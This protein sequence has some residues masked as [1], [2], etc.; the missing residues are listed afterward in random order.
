[1]SFNRRKIVYQ[2]FA[3]LQKILQTKINIKQLKNI[4]IVQENT[5]NAQKFSE[6]I[7]SKKKKMLIIDKY[8]SLFAYQD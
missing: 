6:K 5:R 7:Q 4:E 1:M 3:N 2:E 8:S